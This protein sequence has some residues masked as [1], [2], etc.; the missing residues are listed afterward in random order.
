MAAAQGYAEAQYNL[1]NLYEHGKGVAQ[2]CKAAAAWF[3]KAAASGDADAPA[4]RAVCLAR[5]AAAAASH[6]GSA[7]APIPAENQKA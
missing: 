4:R 1:G 3:A 6:L 7:A 5:A 2:E